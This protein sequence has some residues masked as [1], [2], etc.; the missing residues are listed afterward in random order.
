MN[1]KRYWPQH[2]VFFIATLALFPEKLNGYAVN[3]WFYRVY[4]ISEELDVIKIELEDYK[5]AGYLQYKVVDGL[6]EI[7]DINSQKA[8]ADLT[9]YL[10]RWQNNELLSLPADKP[11]DVAYQQ[12]RLVNAVATAY[13]TNQKE[14]RITL[15]DVYGKPSD[16]S[17]TPP[18]WE[19]VLACQLLD[20]K[21]KIKYMDYDRHA[22]GLYDDDAQPLVDFKIVSKEFEQAIARGIPPTIVGTTT[23]EP[24][25]ITPRSYD[26][27]TGVLFFSGN[28]IP[29]IL[30]KSRRGK[31]VGETTQGGVM[32]KLFKDV[33]ALHKGVPLHTILSVRKDNFDS[34]KRKLAINHLAEINKKVKEVTGV[35]NL[36][37]YDKVNYYIAKPY[38]N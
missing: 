8:V 3:P 15:Q 4:F 9:E 30:Q 23:A 5:N 38:L 32:R 12:K 13:A 36:I 6:Y 2:R 26:T 33:N 28:E 7:S 10:E 25:Y 31:A 17:Y 37:I 11:P 22:D 19:L 18:F 20:K 21:A 16:Y 24:T 27:D 34:K 14:P 35:S 1:M 29:I